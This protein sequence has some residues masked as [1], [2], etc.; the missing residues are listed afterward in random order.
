MVKAVFINQAH[1]YTEMAQLLRMINKAG[2]DDELICTMIRTLAGYLGADALLVS[3]A[4]C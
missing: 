2:K 3:N 1:P 4:P